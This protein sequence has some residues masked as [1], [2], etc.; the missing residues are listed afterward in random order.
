MAVGF[1]FRLHWAEAFHASFPLNLSV[2]WE[3]RLIHGMINGP[4]RM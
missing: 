2:H 1:H 3:T 4:T